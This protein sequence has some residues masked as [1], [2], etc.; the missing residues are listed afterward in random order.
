MGIVSY[1]YN[2][3]IKEE[4]IGYNKTFANEDTSAKI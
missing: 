2:N 3:R 4:E 1:N